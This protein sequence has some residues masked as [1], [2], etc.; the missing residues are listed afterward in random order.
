M[1]DGTAQPYPASIK[2]YDLVRQIGQGGMGSVFEARDRR[3]GSRVALKLLPAHLAADPSFTERFEREAHLAALLRSPYT[4]HL[5][6]FGVEQAQYYLVMELVEGEALST[7]ISRGPLDQDEAL[8]IAGEVA[9]A[10][11]EA[12]ARGVV[13]RDIKPDNILL[14]QQGR[15]KVAD[16]GI[17]RSTAGAGVT[18][19]GSF[20]G[21]PAYAAPEQADGEADQ[22][23]DIY[24][25][26]VTLYAMLAGRVPY[27]GRSA[28]DVML[29]HRTAS[30]P[31]APLGQLPDA[32]QNI[33]RRCL[34]KD[35]LDRYASAGELAGALERARR[36]TRTSAPA[37]VPPPTAQAATPPVV[38][39]SGPTLAPPDEPTR[40]PSAPPQP[41]PRVRLNPAAT[42]VAIP[43][44]VSPAPPAGLGVEPPPP[45]ARPAPQVSLSSLP[46]TPT[47][48]APPPKRPAN[49]GKRR[50][51]LFGGAAAAVLAV[52]A[53]AVIALSGGDGDDDAPSA[54]GETPAAAAPSSSV[55]T[56]T[57]AA[58][59]QATSPPATATPT[60]PPPTP[61]RT[62]TPTPQGGWARINRVTIE[63]GRYSV[64][65]ETSGFTYALPGNHVHFFFDTVPLAQAGAPGTGP[66]VV[67]GGA[68]PFTGYAVGQRPANAR[69][70]CI[71][72][73]NPDHSV[74]AGTGNCVDVP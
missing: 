61:T 65:F 62:P 20:L 70:L 12:A 7:K 73:A 14:N 50:L 29:Q 16:F 3:D 51:A 43:T 8:R 67:Y 48:V 30:L 11:E 31:M 74:R 26:G 38:V 32:V 54:N 9:R 71:L 17:A 53:I 2:H 21:T 18:V 37:T 19:T 64:S 24:A 46:S 45:A 49:T 5:L 34:E 56:G 42:R 1:A 52:A 25:L 59:T 58:T 4:V 39:P 35:P 28:I 6:D 66:W 55:A 72:V 13:H 57:A 27:S 40:T 36:A 47:A 22:R 63:S 33:V 10:L 15:V 41:A 69:Q 60:S 23:S 68:S 44:P